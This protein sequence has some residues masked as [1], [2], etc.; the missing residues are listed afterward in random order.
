MGSRY[1]VALSGLGGD[2]LFAGYRRHFGLL[3]AE[4]YA[5]LPAGVRRIA[6]AISRMVP[7]PRSGGLGVDRLK[8][9]LRTGN[10]AVPDRFLSLMTRLSNDERLALYTPGLR[11]RARITGSA[12]TN[13]FRDVF[14]AQ[15][16]VSGL[17]A[18]LFLDYT[19]FL[20][21]DILALSDRLAMAHSL[22]VRV[23]FV[24]HVLVE[25]VF[26]L[27]QRVKIGSW[28]RA[29]RLLRR[30]LGP[31]L[32]PEH[33]RAPKRGFVGPTAAWLRNELREML[34]DEL[35][36]ERQRRL[37]YFDPATVQMRPSRQGK[38]LSVTCVVRATSRDQL[39]AL[40]RE[41][42]DHPSV[43]MVL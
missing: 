17:S 42:C 22:E 38:Y 39:D 16:S 11:Q 5:K 2:E 13:R 31:R 26:P 30:A 24:D 14:I 15:G 34:T 35:S 18:G 10:G 41:L 19:T 21:D 25:A 7:E 12:A 1:K 6:G 23:P 28:W 32:P 33:L 29:K 36:P 4:H 20:P 9:F 8:R 27:P 40:Y 37:G 43:V 3:A